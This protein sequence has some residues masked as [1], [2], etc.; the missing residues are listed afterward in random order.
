MP[1]YEFIFVGFVSMMMASS[2][3]GTAVFIQN[4]TVEVS[5]NLRK[6]IPSYLVDAYMVPNCGIY[7]DKFYLKFPSP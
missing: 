7:G 4:M 2:N 6:E 5:T 1:K 3:E